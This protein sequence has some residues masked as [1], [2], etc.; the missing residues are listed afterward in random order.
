MR[1]R[2]IRVT[3]EEDLIHALRD[4]FGVEAV[5]IVKAD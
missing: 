4:L 3:P 1:S 2:R 5:H